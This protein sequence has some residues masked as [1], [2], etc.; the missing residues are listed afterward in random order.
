MLYGVS[1]QTLFIINYIHNYFER[2]SDQF[3]LPHKAPHQL[4][5]T[6]RELVVFLQKLQEGG[7]TNKHTILWVGNCLGVFFV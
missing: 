1:S 4:P 6:N 5:R 7:K 3:Q 2:I